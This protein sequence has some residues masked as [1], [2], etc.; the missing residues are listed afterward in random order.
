M[1]M[2][3]I[4]IMHDVAIWN[5]NTSMAGDEVFYA[6]SCVSFRGIGSSSKRCT[7]H[8]ELL[9][10]DIAFVRKVSVALIFLQTSIQ[11]YRQFE[12][13]FSFTA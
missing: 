6:V 2:Y 8:G 3:S 4:I 13:S 9:C 11:K 12:G 1:Y 7:G 5:W 10:E